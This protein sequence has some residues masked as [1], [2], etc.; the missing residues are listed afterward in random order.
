[1]AYKFPEG[2]KFYVARLS[3]MASP[4]T[5][6]AVT[7]ANPAVATATSHGYVDN[8]EVVLFSGWEDAT[9]SVYRVDQQDVNSFQLLGL[10][11]TSTT[12]FPAGSGT[13]TARKI[14]T[15]VEIPQV[16]GISTSGGDAR[17]TQIAPLARRNATAVPTGFNPASITLQV[18]HDP[19][20]ANWSTLV[21][22]SRTLE[23][24]GV[25]I[26]L[27]GGGTQYGY[28]YMSMS[29]IPSMTQNQ[30]NQVALAMSLIGRLISY[31]T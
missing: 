23:A 28:G 21:D 6:T 18:G 29:E 19:A 13:G 14:T 22:I 1:M 15:W 12:Y 4:V 10:N 16:L 25:K 26:V 17:F 11:T 7:N 27:G 20:L 24:C 2:S 8:D 31:S 5:V 30:P 9:D 3:G